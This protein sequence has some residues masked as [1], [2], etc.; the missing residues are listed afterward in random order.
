MSVVRVVCRQLFRN[1]KSRSAWLGVAR[2]M[3]PDVRYGHRAL[4]SL[5]GNG[6][7]PSRLRLFPTPAPWHGRP[8]AVMFSEVDEGWTKE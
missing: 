4:R 1:L 7:P 2:A 5:G 8:R 6:A 3:S